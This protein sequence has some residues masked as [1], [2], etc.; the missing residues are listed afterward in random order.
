MKTAGTPPRKARP[1]ER[2]AGISS[3]HNSAQGSKET[4][5]SEA[6]LDIGLAGQGVEPGPASPGTGTAIRE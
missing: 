3:A 6:R 1:P 4:K 2:R 5:A